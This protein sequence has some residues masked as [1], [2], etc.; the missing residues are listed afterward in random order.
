MQPNCAICNIT[1]EAHTFLHTNMTGTHTSLGWIIG[2]SNPR[3]GRQAFPH[4]L[5][6]A[7]EPIQF[8]IQ[9]VQ[10]LSQG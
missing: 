4:P 6:P 1:D 8:P 9:W 2:R 5:R 7:L 3:G 10:G